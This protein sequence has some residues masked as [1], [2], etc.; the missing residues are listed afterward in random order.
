MNFHRCC[1]VLLAILLGGAV[2][3]CSGDAPCPGFDPFC[4]REAKAVL[5]VKPSK[6]ITVGE[7]AH[8]DAS[9][10]IYDD[11]DWFEFTSPIGNCNGNEK[12]DYVTTR[13]GTIT[14][15]IKAKVDA[16][17]IHSASDDRA[18]IDLVVVDTTTTTTTTLASVQVSDNF[19]DNTIDSSLWSETDAQN[20]LN[21]QNNR[22]EINNPHTGTDTASLLSMASISTNVAVAQAN[23]NWDTVGLSEAQGAVELYADDNNFA[24]IQT[25]A[26]GTG[27]G[28]YRLV[29]KQGGSSVVDSTTSISRG[30]DVKITYEFSTTAINFWYWNGSGW[31]SLLGSTPTHDLGSSLRMRL[32]STDSTLFSHADNV[33]FDN[34]YFV[35]GDYD[36]STPP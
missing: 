13:T 34:V 18:S 21:E 16:I 19:D 35:D 27:N 22:L 3:S 5:K 7:T 23:F 24:A 9:E 15:S 28:N 11:I 29:V 30:Q 6:T 10:S 33:F 8:F 32:M 25:Q 31:E 14:I 12:C 17:G 1:F 2:V 20:R 36:T 26:N 4:K